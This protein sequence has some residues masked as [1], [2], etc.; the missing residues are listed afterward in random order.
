MF[1]GGFLLGHRKRMVPISG[2]LREIKT[3]L[4]FPITAFQAIIGCT[5]QLSD[6]RPVTLADLVVEFD[7]AVPVLVRVA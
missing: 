6:G 3:P 1:E 5:T 4:V 7:G 2:T